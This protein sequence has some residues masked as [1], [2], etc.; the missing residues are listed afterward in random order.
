M[1]NK[2]LLK[3]L[4]ALTMSSAALVGCFAVGC[5]DKSK[6]NEKPDE[7]PAHTTHSYSYT[8]N[9]DG[10]HNGTCDG[11]DVVI[12]NEAHKDANNDNKC[13]LCPAD[14]SV[15]VEVDDVA[16]S[17]AVA[18]KVGTPL[19]LN[20]EVTPAS[21][22]GQVQWSIT[23]GGDKATIDA[24]TG[25]I[26]ATAEG[27]ITVQ[28]TAGDKSATLTLKIVKDTETLTY[29]TSADE[30]V[31]FR[32]TAEP[33][34]TYKLAC[35]IDM[36]GVALEAPSAVLG[37]GATF[38]GDGYT[39][40][41]AS[42]VDAASKTGV[43]LK[44]IN[45]GTVTNVKFLNCAISSSNESVA[46]IAGECNDTGAVSKIEFNSC[47]V[48][49]TN[50]YVGLIFARREGGSAITIS[51]SEITV[52]NGCSTSCAQY[53]GLLVGDMTA[54]T[55]VNF[56]NLHVDGE[57][58][59]S[60]G[61]GSF[62][63]G[64][65]RDGA[66]VSVE[67]AVISATMPTANSIGI[68]VGG[69]AAKLN[70][71]NVLILKTNHP[72][73][74][75]T[76][77]THTITKENLVTVDG[78]TVTD[79]TA[80]NGENTVAYLTDTLGFDFT[81]VWMA[82]GNGYK[83]KAASPNVKSE[84][85]T[86]K[87]LKLNTANAKL[88]FKEGETFSAT[89]LSIMGVYSDGVQLV[90][91]DGAGYTVDSTAFKSEQGKYTI[92]I[93][94]VEDQTIV[95]TYEVNVVKET[96]FKVYDEFMAHSYL[97]GGTLDTANLVVKSVWS[98]GAEETITGY[99]VTASSYDMSTV[100]TYNVSVT[101][102]DYEA[103]TIAISVVNTKPVPVDGKIY[104]NVD[105]ASTVASGVQ[106]KGVETFKTLAEAIDYLEACNLDASV[107]K[108]VNIAAGTYK[109]KI[110]TSLAN[111][112]LIGADKDTTILTYSAVESTYDI[113]NNKQYGLDCATLQVDGAGFGAYNLTIRNDFDYIKDSK[114]E[115]SPQGLA[116]TINGDQAVIANCHLY[117]NQDTLYLKAGRTYLKDT[118]IE[119]NVDFIF[120]NETGLAYFENCEIKAIS[121]FEDSV[122]N[123]SNNGYVTAMRATSANK[124]AYG[125][126]FSNCRFTADEKVVDGS[127]SLGRPWGASATV[128]MINCSFT[129]AYATAA[130]DG[131][132]KSRWYDM[133][134][135]SPVNADFC[136][137]G[138][139]GEGAITE[140][141][142]GGKVLTAEQ[143]AN[144]TKTNIFAAT[145]G[146]C[147]WSAAWDCEAALTALTTGLAGAKVAPNAIYASAESVTVEVG[148][149]VE[150]LV[151][152]APWNA[153]D[154]Q[155]TVTVDSSSIATYANGVVTGVTVGTTTITVTYGTGAS[156]LTKQIPVTVSAAS[157]SG[158][159][160][161]LSEMT[162]D[163]DD[164]ASKA[165]SGD[166][167]TDWDENG[168]IKLY[169]S[170]SK[171]WSY[172]NGS[173][174]SVKDADGKEIIKTTGRMKANGANQ[175]ITVD[176]TN[177]SGNY[178]I[179]LS[180]APS[181]ASER[182]IN[183]AEI[184]DSGAVVGN[185]I[186]SQTT[187]SSDVIY[188]T[189]DI[190]GGKSYKIYFVGNA[191]NFYGINIA[192]VA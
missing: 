13:D 131:K 60:S 163:A 14:L 54:S 156:A 57:F 180:F 76:N 12:T 134:G 41:N 68:F 113:V 29:I 71:K 44:T 138:S 31:A 117:G 155:I 66:T 136:E 17:G 85:A 149:T 56:K 151:S 82:E 88:R 141:V 18:M 140:A 93:K 183:L 153:N 77:K 188:K 148:K 129:K 37:A 128:A 81:D 104:V 122:S 103:K 172:D 96:G 130:Y 19:T 170:A 182:T 1:K 38:D 64:R 97:V 49:T 160:Q 22:A 50:N 87:S 35:D 158:T 118:L 78:V 58:T 119:G 116:L 45:G 187:T 137:Y 4:A 164:L 126:I 63:A 30:L 2:K 51:I 91:T 139:T 70:I 192:P 108:V 75:A 105:S 165:F 15:A 90:L 33:K 24:K 181:G 6:D 80:T 159:E 111:L 52:K 73:I 152:V 5:K 121:R 154:K 177:Y 178:K 146:L 102:G 150:L 109:A 26:T 169:S 61:N 185:A 175:Y 144:Y 167:P 99:K 11:C 114:N 132:T 62:I 69:G 190:T 65:T 157:S 28:V 23:E 16:L 179:T 115:A 101:Y 20:V 162:V 107:T 161:T 55:T 9:G 184:D 27:N 168:L 100:G 166:N 95:G 40:S 171:Q 92:T 83:L 43:L 120:G 72:A 106:V 74:G 145:N 39:I 176:L 94:S 186:Y 125:Y 147:T 25:E 21:A 174:K 89:G 98:D 34:G 143:A 3:L 59:G 133:S 53:G 135:N 47:T 124:P 46:I 191:F 189:C 127:M 67:N 112:T 84:G 142:A 7:P 86:I 36:T 173:G 79:A 42:Y 123:K 48:T 10:T 110:T 32:S 8:D